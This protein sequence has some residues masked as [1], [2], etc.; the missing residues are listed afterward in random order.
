MNIQVSPTVSDSKYRA[1]L[2]VAFKWGRI[3]I[4]TGIYL[5][6]SINLVI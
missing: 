1:S 2:G 4:N 5:D 3:H 6:P